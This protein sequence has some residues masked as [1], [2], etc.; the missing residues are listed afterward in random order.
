MFGE[1]FN[2]ARR[3]ARE[4]TRI[5]L[6]SKAWQ[7]FLTTDFIRVHSRANCFQFNENVTVTEASTLMAPGAK[8]ATFEEKVPETPVEFEFAV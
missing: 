8:V 3:F 1:N 6:T 5:F 4:S 7:I 2:Q